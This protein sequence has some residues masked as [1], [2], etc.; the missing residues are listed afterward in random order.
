MHSEDNK[1]PV[2]QRNNVIC[3]T[4]LC[5]VV[6][7]KLNTWINIFL[8]YMGEQSR[9]SGWGQVDKAMVHE[10]ER[11]QNLMYDTYHCLKHDHE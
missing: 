10:E 6:E 4:T 9:S 7:E 1:I 2:F 11:S 5:M 8:A 3:S